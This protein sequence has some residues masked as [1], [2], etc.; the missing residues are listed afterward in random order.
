M[1][2][3]FLCGV[4]GFSVNNA[5]LTKE[6]GSLA[7]RS[8]VAIRVLKE[9]IRIFGSCTEVPV[10]KELLQSVKQVHSEYALFLEN[11]CKQALLVEEERKK[12]EQAKE[13]ERAAQKAKNDLLEQLKA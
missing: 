1:E 4:R 9:A 7:E 13:Q 6:R 11:E 5:L 8:I 3:V 10:T 2:T 12:V